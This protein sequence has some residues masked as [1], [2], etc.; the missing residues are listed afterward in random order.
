ML[1]FVRFDYISFCPPFLP[2]LLNTLFQVLDEAAAMATADAGTTLGTTTGSCEDNGSDGEG[3]GEGADA[4]GAGGA[5]TSTLPSL[6]AHKVNIKSTPQPA[7]GADTPDNAEA[8]AN[9]LPPTAVQ[10]PAVCC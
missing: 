3:S 6:N 5:S 4:G 2:P 1:V 8:A 7:K 9:T 10:T